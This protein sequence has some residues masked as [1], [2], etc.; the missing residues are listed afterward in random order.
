MFT[1]AC[2]VQ[3]TCVVASSAAVLKQTSAIP[4]KRR[5]L[6]VSML[7]GIAITLAATG[8]GL[9]ATGVRLTYFFQPTGLC[10]VAGGTLGVIFITTPRLNLQFSARRALELFRVAETDRVALI[11]ELM[12]YVK[13]ARSKGLLTIEPAIAGAS[14]QFLK[15]SLELC[16]DADDRVAL[17]S[18]LE[19]KI[20]LTERHGEMD[21][22]VLDVAGGFAPTIGVL[23]TVVGLIEVLR[24][25]SD[26]ATVAGGIGAA[27]VSTIYGLGLA[28]MILLPAAHRI[29]ARVAEQFETNEMIAEAVAC[30]AEATHPALVRERLNAFLRESK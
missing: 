22:K 18:A 13:L 4:K 27:F 15:E 9:I 21:A 11:E 6:D 30:M 25:F 19:T 28:N 12:S 8:A 7:L 5:S 26:L 10:I 3:P 29:R 20:R 24:N 14:T 17:R 2:N 23:G 16:L 1:M